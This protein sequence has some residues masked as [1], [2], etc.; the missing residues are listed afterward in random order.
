MKFAALAITTASLA[1]C[2]FDGTSAATT[3]PCT[4]ADTKKALALSNE[5]A[6][7]TSCLASVTGE[8]PNAQ[9]VAAIEKVLS[10]MP[11]CF[12]SDAS[13][14]ANYDSLLTNCKSLT[15]TTAPAAT[16]KTPSTTTKIPSTTNTSTTTTTTTPSTTSSSSSTPS[17]TVASVIGATTAPA[18]A[19][20]SAA[21]LSVSIALASAAAVVMTVL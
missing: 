13:P 7:D 2:S 19:A 17:A 15:T 12:I 10:E 4:D 6:T 21:G 8:C 16:T 3:A 20:S 1:L 9:C 5:L 11:A 18:A 14:L